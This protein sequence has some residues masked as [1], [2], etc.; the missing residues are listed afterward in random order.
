MSLVGIFGLLLA[1]AAVFVADL[2]RD[3]RRI[4][5]FALLL[6]L[7]TGM[8]L[9]YYLFAEA[10]GSDAQFY[11]YDPGR[12]RGE[13]GLGTLFVIN[14]VQFLRDTL[15]GTF[16]DYF[17]LF[18]VPGVW[19]LVLMMRVLQETFAELDERVPTLAYLCLLLPGLHFW[20]AA[21]GK[22]SPLF[23]ASACAVW[24][25]RK[26]EKR[27]VAL[28]VAIAVALVFRPHIAILIIAAVGGALVLDRHTRFMYK[29]LLIAGVAALAMV[30]LGDLQS[31]YRLDFSNPE[32]VAEFVAQRSDV[33]EESGGS[34]ELVSAGLPVKIASLWVR[35]LF[36]D[37][38]TL[39]A[40]VASAENIA[41]LSIMLFILVNAKTTLGLVNRVLFVRYSALFFMLTTLLLGAVNYNIGLGLRQKMMAMP[42]LLAIFFA[43]LAVRMAQARQAAALEQIALRAPAQPSATAGRAR[44]VYHP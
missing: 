16:L 21:I 35:P 40:Y 25:A 8:C 28:G 5:V 36:F 41:I 3:R 39:L 44:Q 37:A 43:V 1:L 22:D 24:A 4:A 34:A 11:Y 29:A 31:S 32:S 6:V 18:R 9:L 27:Y 30:G 38:D 13:R 7:H 42:A 20:T 15:G 19:G 14:M 2:R 23:F 26:I 12:W 10:T 33:S 17:L